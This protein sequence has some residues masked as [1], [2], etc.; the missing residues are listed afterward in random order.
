[1]NMKSWSLKSDW[2]TVSKWLRTKNTWA[3]DGIPLI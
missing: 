1:M 2:I 3:T